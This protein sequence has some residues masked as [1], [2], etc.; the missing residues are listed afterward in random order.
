M[1]QRIQTVFLFFVFAISIAV[2]FLPLANY[3]GPDFYYRLNAINVTDLQNQSSSIPDTFPQPYPLLIIMIGIAIL[4]AFI[5]FS[6]KNRYA[7]MKLCK[8]DMLLHV[9]FIVVLFFY[10]DSM[11]KLSTLSSEYG[12]GAMLPLIS[13]V[14]LFL[15]SRSIKKDEDLVKSQDRLR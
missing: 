10:A 11:E 1:I 3:D 2:C 6:Y 4:T 14:L 5:I 8:L 13:L 12:I 7:Q 15:A 9:V